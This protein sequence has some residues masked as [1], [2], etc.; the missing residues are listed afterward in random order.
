L[1]AVRVSPASDAPALP[2]A[3][4]GRAGADRR[5]ELV[6]TAVRLF[7]EHSYE[8][9][10]VDYIAE[11]AGVAKGLLYYY[12]GNKRGLYA[13][14]LERVAAELRE[15]IVIATA[16]PS[17]EPKE[18]LHSAID[19]HLGYVEQRSVAYRALLS[20]VGAHPEV[21]EVL[22]VE[23]TFHRELLEERLP[24]EVPRGPALTVALKG[25]QHFLDGAVFAWLEQRTL[26]RARVCE[27]CASTF[28]GIMLAACKVHEESSS[29]T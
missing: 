6:L 16:D 5:E 7:S 10:S 12:F 8:D 24:V 19:A 18:L 2:D 27:L 14:A 28:Y 3:S 15:Q 29:D 9:V 21:R 11:Q 1:G 25:W 13:R 20:G 17:L 26:D 23:R 4:T 22:E